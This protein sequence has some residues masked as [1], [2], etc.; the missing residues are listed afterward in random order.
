MGNVKRKTTARQSMPRLCD[1]SNYRN[2]RMDGR[3]ALTADFLAPNGAAV[4]IT[5]KRYPGDSW[6][7]RLR[8]HVTEPRRGLVI[9][10]YDTYPDDDMKA[11]WLALVAAEANERGEV[12]EAAEIDVYKAAGSC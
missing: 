11:L 1:V 12:R 3:D 8:V 6:E 10:L 2:V 9:P 5:F 7:V 4:A